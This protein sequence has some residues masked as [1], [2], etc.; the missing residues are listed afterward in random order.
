MPDLSP[1]AVHALAGSVPASPG[2]YV[3]VMAVDSDALITVGRAGSALF[4]RGYYA[5]VGS[6]LGGL[7]GRLRR[8]VEGP[9]RP[10]W[11][12][13]YLLALARPVEIW[14]REGSERLECAWATRLREVDGLSPTPF[15]F[16]ASDCHCATHLF[17]GPN[18]PSS[19]VLEDR[20]LGV[21][22]CDEQQSCTRQ[23][24]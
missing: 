15:R 22:R 5:Y 24:A 1:A 2:T 9:R 23:R 14:Y 16:G 12:I 18:R 11:H 21:L 3:L 10:H 4:A 13:D 19:Q 7:R 6:A 8:Y 17:F 20:A